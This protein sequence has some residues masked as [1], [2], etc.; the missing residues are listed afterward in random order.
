[1]R[2]AVVAAVVLTFVAV[3]VIADPSHESWQAKTWQLVHHVAVASVG[4]R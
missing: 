2:I 3:A 4:H 1:V